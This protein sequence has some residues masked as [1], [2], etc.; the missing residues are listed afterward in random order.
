MILIMII[1]L[2]KSI[3]W[4]SLIFGL[5]YVSVTISLSE[6]IRDFFTLL[7]TLPFILTFFSLGIA[8]LFIRALKD[9]FKEILKIKVIT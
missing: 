7:L 2:P 1:Y 5:V 4:F 6:N 8:R 9:K 3:L